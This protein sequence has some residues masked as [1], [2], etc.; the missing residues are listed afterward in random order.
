M[1]RLINKS[2]VARWPL[3]VC[4]L[5]VAA[6][7]GACTEDMPLV[8]SESTDNSEFKEYKL[9]AEFCVKLMP[10]RELSSRATPDFDDGND[11][12]YALALPTEAEAYHYL[13]IYSDKAVKPQAVLVLGNSG[14]P[15]DNKKNNLTLTITKAYAST[16]LSSTITDEASMKDWLNGK[17][18]YALLNFSKSVLDPAQTVNINNVETPINLEGSTPEVIARFTANQLEALKLKEY[19]ITAEGKD[20]FVMSNS[21]YYDNGA[22]IDCSIYPNNVNK[23][24]E[25]ALNNPAIEIH[26]E[27]VAVRYDVT[28]APDIQIGDVI[29]GETSNSLPRINTKSLVK[30]F[31]NTNGNLIIGEE[32]Y[33]IPYK[34]SGW[35]IEVT[36]Y[37][38]NGLEETATLFKK[39]SN[40]NSLLSS[41]TWNEPANNRS[42]W[43]DDIHYLITEDNLKLY[44]EQFRQSLEVTNDVRHLHD[45]THLSNGNL[46]VTA[47][48]KCNLLYKP[49]NEFEGSNRTLYSFENTY[50]D[51]DNL[52]GERGYYSA[53]THLILTGRIKI[54][55]INSY[56]DLYYDQN[57]IF[58]AS[59]QDLFA[60]KLEI[61]NSII[62]RNGVHGLRVLDVNW[63]RDSK[64][65]PDTELDKNG[66]K[67][68]A[69]Q[70][71]S[72]LWVNRNNVLREAKADDFRLIPAEIAGGDGSLLLAPEASITEIYLAPKDENGNFNDAKKTKITGNDLISLIHKQIGSIDHFKEGRVYYAAPIPHFKTKVEEVTAS[73]LGDTGVVRNNWYEVTVTGIGGVGRPI[74]DET[75]PIIPAV[76]VKRSYLNLTIEVKEWHRIT[77]SVEDRWL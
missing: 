48:E 33:I 17:T 32:S 52:L 36:G 11:N 55:S 75:Q 49:F 63:L 44:P 69:W 71:G 1:K 50:N 47:K 76:E 72:V 24:K 56:T 16:E 42:Y 2:A 70:N 46:D 66:M 67:I 15:D 61:L 12:E 19:K 3:F 45:G 20:Y 23:E 7:L 34:E 5:L 64:Y 8:P 28:F 43:A 40:Y 29:E 73:G 62:L 21:V 26:V 39:I 59:E 68:L 4:G 54:N 65:K 13:L 14:E 53:G 30:V 10:N 31:D 35:E 58:Y 37:G 60:A 57:S 25:V 77:Q 38:V 9:P 22:K 27:R 41:V 51:A 18:A 74:D 6:L